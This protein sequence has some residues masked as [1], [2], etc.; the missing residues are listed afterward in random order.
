MSEMNTQVLEGMGAQGNLNERVKQFFL[1]PTVQEILATAGLAPGK[2]SAE[3]SVDLQSKGNFTKNQLVCISEAGLKLAP[4]SKMKEVEEQR[5]IPFTHQT[6]GLKQEPR[7]NEEVEEVEVSHP[8][9]SYLTLGKTKN[10]K[11]K[12]KNKKQKTKNKKQKKQRTKNKEQRTKNK[13]QRTKNKEQRTKNKEQRTEQNRT[14]QNRT[15][16]NKTKQNKTKQN[17]T[18]QNKT[19]QNKTKQNKTKQNKRE[20]R[21]FKGRFGLQN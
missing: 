2:L 12:T 21:L 18:K 5:Q 19:K 9:L 10:K 14:E 8:N 6:M 7:K 1:C 17:K 16:Q 13:E 3:A 15:K 4:Y 11:Q 20:K